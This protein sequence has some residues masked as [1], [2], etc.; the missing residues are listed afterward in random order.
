MRLRQYK[1]SK[2]T[3]FNPKPQVSRSRSSYSRFSP[4]SLNASLSSLSSHSSRSSRSGSPLAF[5]SNSARGGNK[6]QVRRST[7]TRK[8]IVMA[9]GGVADGSKV[10]FI[11]LGIM[12]KA[13]AINLQKAGYKVVVWNR[14]SSKCDELVKLGATG[15]TSF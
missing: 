2:Q 11:G 4:S 9:S 6:K 5:L 1:H 15:N 12:G 7:S 10:G 8:S 14:T 3:S 13:M